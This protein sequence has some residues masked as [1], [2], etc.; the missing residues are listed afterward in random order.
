MSNL[1]LRPLLAVGLCLGAVIACLVPLGCGG[2]QTA[3]EEQEKSNL[4]PLAILYGKFLPPHRGQPPANEDELK[5]FIKSLSK[6]ELDSLG[7]TDVDSLFVSSRDGKPYKIV[8]GGA[9]TPEI[10]AYEQEGVEG[11]RFVAD[12]LGG[13][14]SVDEAEFKKLV[15]GAK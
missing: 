7:V 13:V 4:K 6:E 9:K 10:V 15:P 12:N 11:K 3:T 1:G 8:Y 14:R 2:T 5:Q